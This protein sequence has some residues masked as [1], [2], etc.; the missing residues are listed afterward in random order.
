MAERVAASGGLGG[1]RSECG[2]WALPDLGR[3]GAYLQVVMV[4]CQR[5]W[6]A[7]EV[8]GCWREVSVM[9]VRLGSSLGVHGGLTVRCGSELEWM[10][11]H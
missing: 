2:G 9:V 5:S 10:A 4:N 11:Q 6:R 3:G 7:R 1:D 8:N